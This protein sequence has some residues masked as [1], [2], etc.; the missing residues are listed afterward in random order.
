M[1]SRLRNVR[2]GGG[3]SECDAK[4][5]GINR[6]RGSGRRATKLYTFFFC[7]GFSPFLS[8]LPTRPALHVKTM[9]RLLEGW[10][11]NGSGGR[12]I[13]PNFVTDDGRVRTVVVVSAGLWSGNL[14]S[15][16][17]GPSLLQR[18]RF[19][20][21]RRGQSRIPSLAPPPCARSPRRCSDEAPSR[22][23]GCSGSFYE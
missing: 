19:L 4:P 20:L 17:P 7:V 22:E 6:S 18:P 1:K 10:D 23:H 21:V 5:K 11:G 2:Q 14:G 9:R 8:E 3:V 16:A 13:G 15:N 12:R